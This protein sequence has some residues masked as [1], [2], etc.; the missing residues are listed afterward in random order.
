M[1]EGQLAEL[2]DGTVI[3]DV[4]QTNGSSRKGARSRGSDEA[5]PEKR[6]LYSG[7]FAYSCLT[8]LSEGR[9]G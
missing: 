9:L 1:N 8:Q 2:S 6:V 5:R 4:R 7:G 3:M